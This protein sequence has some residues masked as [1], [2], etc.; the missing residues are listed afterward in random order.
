MR[1][2]SAACLGGILL[3]TL[4]WGN[5]SAADTPAAAA[6]APSGVGID[7]RLPRTD[8]GVAL[9]YKFLGCVKEGDADKAE[10]FAMSVE[11][12]LIAIPGADSRTLYHVDGSLLQSW[13]VKRSLGITVSDEGVLTGISTS[14]ADQTPAILAGGLKILAAIAPLLASA[15]PP[16]CLEVL[17]HFYGPAVAALKR[18]ADLK[19]KI[20]E[21]NTL[22]ADP[23]TPPSVRAQKTRLRTL[24]ATEL[25]RV[26]DSLAVK[27]NAK[28]N[29]GEVAPGDHGVS[30]K[31]ELDAAPFASW[32]S[33]TI[34]DN[35]RKQLI[36]HYFGI[37]F[38]STKL[39][40][41]TI[42]AITSAKPP[43]H[44]SD[45]KLAISVP[46]MSLAHVNLLPEGEALAKTESD[47]S[48]AHIDVPL[49]QW[50]SPATLCLDAGFGESTTLAF[51]YDKF[52]RATEFQWGS[53]ATGA[54]I[55]AAA[56][57]ATA[58]AMTIYKAVAGPTAL[59]EA[60]AELDT[61]DTQQ[62][63]NKLRACKAILDAGG[64]DCDATPSQ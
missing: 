18:Q 57:G 5:A 4:A 29:L 59:E 16:T 13:R 55:V 37:K 9:T 23:V 24:L 22:L 41:T 43:K 21:L 8:V 19:F 31:L 39:S 10:K 20:A 28:I 32:F 51:K 30:G 42:A 49:A 1:A 12:K 45:C 56:A 26:E 15:Q 53:E 58:D 54:N 62:K 33:S 52:G 35:V 50:E 27:T 14:N 38:E 36:G 47:K 48:I 7:Y 60:K 61:L 25:V 34:A 3:I 64:S 17:E 11:A 6:T 2:R 63:L 44:K 40:P 46:K